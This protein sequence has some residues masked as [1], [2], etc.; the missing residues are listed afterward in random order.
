M[1]AHLSENG[2]ELSLVRV[3]WGIYDPLEGERH[4]LEDDIEAVVSCKGFKGADDIMIPEAAKQVQRLRR[5]LGRE[6]SHMDKFDW[7]GF[8]Y[9]HDQ[10]AT[11]IKVIYLFVPL[12]RGFPCG[13]EL[14]CPSCCR[15]DGSRLRFVCLARAI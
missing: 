2:R 4:M 6:F 3:S 7:R 5:R 15:F 1:E 14:K 11:E 10:G 9:S 13:S 8:P 12:P